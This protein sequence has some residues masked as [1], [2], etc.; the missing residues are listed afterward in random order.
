[1]DDQLAALQRFNATLRQFN[2]SLRGSMNDLRRNHDK[3]LPLWRDSFR[4]EYDRRWTSFSGP[5]ERYNKG[6]G[7]R[8]ERFVNEKIRAISRYLHGD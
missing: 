8:Y 1:V 2:H 3:V 7:D 6:Q 5:V 4:R